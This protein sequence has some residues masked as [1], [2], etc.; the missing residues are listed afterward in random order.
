MRW[1][2]LIVLWW[3]NWTLTCAASARRN[4]WRNFTQPGV[5]I[6]NGFRTPWKHGFIKG[7]VCSGEHNII[8][9]THEDVSLSSR[10]VSKKGHELRLRSE[11]VLSY[12]RR[13]EDVC[14][15]S[16]N[17]QVVY[18]RPYFA[19]PFLWRAPLQ[20]V[21]WSSVIN[22]GCIVQSKFPPGL[23]KTGLES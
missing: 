14:S 20:L 22:M 15:A 6:G 5:H 19:E 3:W 1:R 12:F 21:H 9:S 10:V 23:R 17:S 7:C 4:R 11:F 18:G 16:E 8:W 2:F 13:D